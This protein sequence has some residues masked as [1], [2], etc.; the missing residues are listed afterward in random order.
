[1]QIETTAR[2]H[3][4]PVKRAIIKRQVLARMWRKGNSRALFMRMETGAATMENSMKL[5]QK[6]KNRTT[7]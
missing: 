2:Y 1:M 4:T 3:F 6:I 5:P 7:I